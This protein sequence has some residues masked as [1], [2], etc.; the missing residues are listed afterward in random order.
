MKRPVS[1]YDGKVELVNKL[2]QEYPAQAVVCPISEN[3]VTS[4]REGTVMQS[5]TAYSPSV[6]RML[7]GFE[8]K[9]GRLKPGRVYIE[10]AEPR[11]DCLYFF[12]AVTTYPLQNERTLASDTNTIQRATRNSFLSWK[13]KSQNV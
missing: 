5:L 11:L 7:A 8:R 6:C 1:Y 13:R 4:I 9:E 10:T 3:D 2:L 12:N